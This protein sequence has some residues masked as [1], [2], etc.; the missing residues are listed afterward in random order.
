M[1]NTTKTGYFH[2]VS[3]EMQTD[4][5]VNNATLEH[6]QVAIEAGAV[7]ASTN[8]TYPSK[9]PTD[10]LN[11]LI[12]AALE[13][14]HNDDQIA[15]EVYRQTVRNLQKVFMDRYDQS[16]GLEGLVAIQGDPRVNADKEAV[17]EGALEYFQKM[18]RNIIVKVPATPVGAYALEELTAMGRPTIATLGFSV[19]QAVYLSEAYERGLQRLKSKS[20]QQPVCY[21]VYIAGIFED[22]LKKQNEEMGNPIP[23]EVI[24]QAGNAV[25]REV[26]RILKQRQ[27]KTR[28]IGGGARGLHH[29]TGQIGGD[30]AI[31]IGWD[32]IDKL[33][34]LDEPV[35]SRIEDRIPDDV[36]AT[37]DKV[38]PDFGKSLREHSL[39]PEEFVEFPP[40]A[41]FQNA[42]LSGVNKLLTAIA[43]RKNK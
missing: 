37:L 32:M 34:K 41:L 42:F 38:L 30:Q 31:T 5:W 9:L 29:F 15:E 10:Y 27:F 17:L 18:D 3:Q 35:L 26:Y 20:D 22:S 6:A 4:L 43:D 24:E 39:K 40:V 2:R 12:D 11:G 19:D 28:L 1:V 25:H 8:P 16:K 23:I 33:Q 7:S 36:V 13:Q 14:D 21:I